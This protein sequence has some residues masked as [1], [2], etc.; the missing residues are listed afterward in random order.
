MPESNRVV[1]MISFCPRHQ[2]QRHCQSQLQW[3]DHAPGRRSRPIGQALVLAAVLIIAAFA[4]SANQRQ[5]NVTLAWDPSPDGSVAGYRLYD[6][7]SSG[8]YTNVIDVGNAT[9]ATVSNLVSG[10]TYFFAA[11]AYDTNGQESVFSNEVSYTVPMLTNGPPSLVMTSPANNSLYVAPATINFTANVSPN[12]HTVNWVEFYDGTNW[13]GA[14][15]SAPYSFSWR[16]V[17]SGT[18]SLKAQVVYDSGSTVASAAVSVTVLALWPP[19]GLTFAADSGTTGLTFGGILAWDPSPDSAVAGYLCEV[20]AIGAYTNVIDVGNATSAT[21]TNLVMGDSYSFAVRTY[22]TNGQES[23]FSD[24][25]SYT[26][27]RPTNGPPAL[28]LTSPANGAVYVAPATIN[29]TVDVIPDGHAISQ[30]RFYHGTN[31][32]GAVISAP[33]RF[34]WNGVGVG[35]YSLSAQ[36]VDDSGST[37]ASAAVNVTVSP[38]KIGPGSSQPS[39]FDLLQQ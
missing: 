3:S 34:S 37:F 13:L 33:Y 10:V 20:V 28:A 16:N 1:G 5:F 26:V 15:S 35:T 9:N 12:F 11:T 4:A 7:V 6:G 19:S 32:L 30:V 18:Y 38:R 2:F 39:T 24:E 8:T 23:I 21:V 25:I 14:A 17:G 29:F 31:W 36:L 22:D 27:P